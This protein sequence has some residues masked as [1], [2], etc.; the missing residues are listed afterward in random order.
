[1]QGPSENSAAKDRSKGM[2]DLKPANLH[3]ITLKGQWTEE[4]AQRA[5]RS[6][7]KLTTTKKT[8]IDLVAAQDDAMAIGI[9]K[10]FS[11]S[12]ERSGPRTLAIGPRSWELTA[13]RKRGRPGC[14]AASC[15]PLF[16]AR[17]IPGRQLTCWLTRCNT[18]RISPK[19]RSPFRCPCLPST[20]SARKSK[21]SSRPSEQISNTLKACWE[22]T[23]TGIL[24][25]SPEP[26]CC[27]AGEL[28]DQRLAREGR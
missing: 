25:E 15:A 22:V 8:V 14:A 1:M 28:P 7:L 20:H 19:R 23:S 27:S 6:W 17:Q 5:V 4:S 24:T 26:A 12:V 16:S 21:N 13:C 3:L 2:Q 18:T 10:V 11:G 9:R